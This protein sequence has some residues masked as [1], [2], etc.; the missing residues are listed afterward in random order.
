MS[1][2]IIVTLKNFVTFVQYGSHLTITSDNF[3]TI[4]FHIRW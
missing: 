3:L 2:K 1:G 4:I